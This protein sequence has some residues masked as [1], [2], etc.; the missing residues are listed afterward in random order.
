MR[1]AALWIIVLMTAALLTGAAVILWFGT[2]QRSILFI[3]D[4]AHYQPA[5]F[6]IRHGRTVTVQSA[7]G[8]SL[9]GWYWPP[10]SP[11]RE[12]IVYF[13]GNGN[14]LSIALHSGVVQAFTGAGYGF[15]FA[16]YRGFNGNP[17]IPTESGL[18]E[19]ARAW[20]RSVE[21]P[22]DH[23]VLYGMSLGTGV[24]VKMATE[25]P[26]V[27]GVILEAPYTSFADIIRARH[28]FMPYDWVLKHHFDSASRM[29]TLSMPVLVLHGGRD[30]IVPAAQGRALC[31]AAPDCTLKLYDDAAHDDLYRHGAYGEALR[32]LRRAVGQSPA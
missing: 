6:D 24:A 19:D 25:Y 30:M 12:T 14:G 26:D 29:A 11:D 21:A 10:V 20:M 5:D 2:N 9:T 27:T 18:Y 22:A 3:P 1:R 4:A 13:H 31:A 8:V 32:F 23:I 28:P 7:P 17:G 16:T 15:L